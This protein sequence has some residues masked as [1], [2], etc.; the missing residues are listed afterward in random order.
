MRMALAALM[1]LTLILPASAESP[2]DLPIEPD[3]VQA[4]VEQLIT[5][6]QREVLQEFHISEE[7]GQLLATQLLQ[8]ALSGELDVQALVPQAIGMFSPEQMEKMRLSDQQAKLLFG[9]MDQLSR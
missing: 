5:P 1:V 6:G 3:Q 9:L 8:G 2:R 4:L 7:A